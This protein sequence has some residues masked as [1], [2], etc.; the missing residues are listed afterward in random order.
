MNVAQNWAEIIH[1]QDSA[2]APDQLT[3]QRVSNQNTRNIHL[4]IKSHL[5]TCPALTV[6]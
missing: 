3:S 5:P 4:E 2:L 6:H 1:V